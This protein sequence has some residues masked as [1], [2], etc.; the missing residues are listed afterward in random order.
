M[1]PKQRIKPLDA[2]IL[3]AILSCALPVTPAAFAAAGKAQAQAQKISS[4]LV[5]TVSSSGSDHLTEDEEVNIRVYKV[6]N[7]GVV[8][9]S[10]ASSAEEALV[11][12]N[13]V[14]RDSF[15]SGSI[16][17]TD[18]YILTN[19]H[20]VD[21]FDHVRVTLYDGS[22]VHGAVV[23]VDPQT[24]LAI[25][26]IDPPKGVKLT[27]IAL[28]DSEKMEVGRK[29]LAIGNP[30]G[31]DRT[32]TDG[33]VSSVGR[34][35]NTASGRAIK[36]IIQ[37]DAAINPGNSGGPLLDSQGRMIGINTAIFSKAGQSAGIGFAI[38]INIAKNIIPQLITHHKVSRPEIGLDVVLLQGLRVKNVTKG[39][40]ADAAGIQGPKIVQY[41]L[42][43][44][45]I[46]N[47]AEWGDTITEIDGQKVTTIDGFFSYI[48][49]KKPDQ[50]VTLTI[51]RA[52]KTLKIPVKLTLSTAN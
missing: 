4:K 35:M 27:I 25:V 18:G 24:D 17:N 28:G 34:T 10:T 46:L 9:I 31:L 21:G 49:S 48:E 29:V 11:N 20:V 7:R 26:K 33:I 3:S 15:G 12:P 39:S 41:N 23:G 50:T 47:K 38:P 22:V 37:T 6:A 32:L 16:I 14:G 42:G 51:L 45:F 13:N 36:G 52:G 2:L 8:N 30:F 5:T 40:P 44:G 43:N 1:K 19:Y